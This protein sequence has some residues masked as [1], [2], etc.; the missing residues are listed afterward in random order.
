M[1]N[2]EKE[3]VDIPVQNRVVVVGTTAV[4]VNPFKF[5]F[6]KGALLYLPGTLDPVPN[7]APIWIGNEKVTADLAVET[8]GFPLI[9]GS[10]LNIPTDYLEGLYAVSTAVDQHILWIGV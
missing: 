1:T 9:P 5:R 7:T 4:L 2:I 3:S 10:S 6:M 8:G